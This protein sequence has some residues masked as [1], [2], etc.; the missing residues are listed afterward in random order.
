M[1]EA[2]F[3]K[4]MQAYFQK[5]RFK[6]PQPKILNK[7]L[8][9][10]PTDIDWFF[11][12]LQSDE[13]VSFTVSKPEVKGVETHIQVTNNCSFALACAINGVDK[14]GKVK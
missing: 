9:R 14:E 5:W 13:M 7:C 10:M 3:D 8:K 4:A 6:H 11:T 1:G 2:S 12:M